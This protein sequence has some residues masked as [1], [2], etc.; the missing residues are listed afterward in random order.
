M[1]AL[2][3]VMVAALEALAPT[4]RFPAAP[5][6]AA[7]ALLPR[8]EPPLPAWVRV[9]APVLPKA[10]GAMLELDRLH[11]A[12]NP[13]GPALAAKL[14]WTAADALGCEY[15]RVTALADLKRAG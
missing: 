14:R 8:E 12:D 3:P 10:T 9:L 1:H 15:G 7:W 5:P 2:I 13:V 6:D 11:R 4:G